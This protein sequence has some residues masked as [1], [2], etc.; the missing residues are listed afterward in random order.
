MGEFPHI[1]FGVFVPHDPLLE[2]IREQIASLGF[3]LVDLR[4]SGP[5]ARPLLQIRID[6]PDAEPGRGVT[7]GD[8][9]VVSR[10]LEQFL[11]AHAAVGPRYVLE[12]SSPGLERPVRW[13]E[14][15]RRYIGRDVRVRLAADRK[16]RPRPARIVA[17]PDEA[18]VLLEWADGRQETV[19]LDD[20]KGATL[21]VDWDAIAQR[22]KGPRKG[23]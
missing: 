13:P 18:H 1:F 4:R 10:S 23:P 19:A 17:V 21:A 5:P 2:P 16:A 7:T 6:V 12:V 22:S 20:I 15:W 3:E 9:T 8:C 11:E 14:H